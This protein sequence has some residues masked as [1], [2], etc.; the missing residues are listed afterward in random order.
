MFMGFY[1]LLQF[2]LYIVLC[3]RKKV[4]DYWIDIS[5]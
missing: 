1:I 4:G 5:F 3:L 2:L